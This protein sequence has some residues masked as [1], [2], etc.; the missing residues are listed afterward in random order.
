[1]P[2]LELTNVYAGYKD[3]PVLSDI[4]IS[5]EEGQITSIVGSNGAGK[6]TLLRT[7]SGLLAPSAG[8]I[9]FAGQDITGAQPHLIVEMGISQVP[10][11]RQLF[12]HMTVEGNLLVGSHT[13]SAKEHRQANLEWV[14]ELFPILKERRN[15]LARTLSGGEQQMLATGRALMSNP[16]LLMLDEPSLGLAPLLVDT[17]FQVVRDICNRGTT[18][19]LIEQ[20][21]QQALE[22]AEQAYVLE[23]GSVVMRGNGKAL[24]GNEELRKAYLG[25]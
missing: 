9:T 19:L 11:G 4:T 21:V 2:L 14:F 23:N 24:L 3:A 20:N 13:K 5:V 8:K 18:V 10:E 25:L 17:V 6:T 15:Q 1:M 7:I 16:K 22:M 12:P